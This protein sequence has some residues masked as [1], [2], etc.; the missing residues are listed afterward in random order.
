MSSTSSARIFSCTSPAAATR[1]RAMSRFAQEE[2]VASVFDWKRIEAE[3]NALDRDRMRANFLGGLVA[4]AFP[5]L[6]ALAG[7]AILT[8]SPARP[9]AYAAFVGCLGFGFFFQG[10]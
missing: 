5:A 6:G 10:I 1:W 9:S 4:Y 2:G 8:L 3:G 7:V